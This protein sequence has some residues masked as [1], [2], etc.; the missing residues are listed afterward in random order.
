MQIEKSETIKQPPRPPA[1]LP[2]LAEKPNFPNLKP[3]FD[4]AFLEEN[5][6]GANEKESRKKANEKIVIVDQLLEEFNDI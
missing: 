4:F 6:P 1:K 5:E 2:P 3:D